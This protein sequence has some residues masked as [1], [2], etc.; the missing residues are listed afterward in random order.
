MNT[1]EISKMMHEIYCKFIGMGRK[2]HYYDSEIKD[3]L[4]SFYNRTEIDF[5]E[6]KDL[7]IEYLDR[8][9]LDL[10]KAIAHARQRNAK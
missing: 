8:G 4:I 6:V 7:W 10:P 9:S 5:E 1:P 2:T 3:F